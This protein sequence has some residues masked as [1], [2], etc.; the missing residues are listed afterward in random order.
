MSDVALLWLQGERDGQTTGFLLFQSPLSRL[1]QS[2]SL[3]SLQVLSPHDSEAAVTESSLARLLAL[4]CTLPP[5]R[6]FYC[7]HL[8][9]YLKC[10]V[11][12]LVNQ[13]RRHI[14]TRAWVRDSEIPLAHDI[15][16]GERSGAKA[17]EEKEGAKIP[18][19]PGKT[20]SFQSEMQPRLG[21][22]VYD[23]RELRARE[24]SRIPPICHR[25]MLFAN[26]RENKTKTKTLPFL[27]PSPHLS[28][29]HACFISSRKGT[30]FLKQ[31]MKEKII[32]NIFHFSGGGTA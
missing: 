23:L 26:H 19:F 17:Q 25:V 10:L 28:S 15:S 14:C 6:G 5:G 18:L 4:E 31:L 12:C 29:P 13:G 20:P 21:R 7:F 30:C 3:A 11:Q 16:G 32:T 2:L 24:G 8:P 22:K 9:M 1:F 27:P